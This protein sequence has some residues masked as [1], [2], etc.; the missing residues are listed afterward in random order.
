MFSRQYAV[1][2]GIRLLAQPFYAPTGCLTKLFSCQYADTDL[3]CWM[4]VEAWRRITPA[5][6]RKRDQKS[7]DIKKAYLNK[8]YFFGPNSP[9]GKEGQDKVSAFVVLMCFPLHVARRSR[10]E[11][12][13]DRPTDKRQ[14]SRQR[15]TERQVESRAKVLE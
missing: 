2:S 12:E 9:A 6:E 5:E 15:Q 10:R 3:K 11:G 13:T 14:A 7:K 1:I 4:D 8:K